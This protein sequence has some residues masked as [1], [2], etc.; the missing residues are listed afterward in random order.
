MLDAVCMLWT[1]FVHAVFLFG[2]M[3][4]WELFCVAAR[5]VYC[6]M[7]AL[8]HDFDTYQYHV[9][10]FFLNAILVVSLVTVFVC[11]V[12]L[13]VQFTHYFV[14][15]VCAMLM[16]HA[17]M[18]ERFMARTRTVNTMLRET[19]DALEKSLAESQREIGRLQAMLEDPLPQSPE[20]LAM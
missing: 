5:I 18:A 4:F 20:S 19:I 2:V 6:A 1:L 11:T 3:L 15:G 17:V 9:V 10:A 12:L 7:I 13:L 16:I 14:V 8:Y